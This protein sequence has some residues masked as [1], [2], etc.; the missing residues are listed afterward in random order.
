MQYLMEEHK[1]DD[2]RRA[3]QDEAFRNELYKSMEFDMH[4]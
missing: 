4:K 3:V 1:L 2:A